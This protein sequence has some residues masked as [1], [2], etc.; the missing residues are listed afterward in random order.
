MNV[1]FSDLRFYQ[2]NGTAFVSLPYQIIRKTNGVSV[3]VFVLIP[4]IPMSPTV[5][6][7]YMTYGNSSYTPQSGPLSNFY[8]FDDFEDGLYTGR[9]A[10]YLNWT[11]NGVGT[12]SITNSSP[13][14]GTYSLKF[15]G[16][17]AN[18]ISNRITFP[19]TSTQFDLTFNF[20]LITQ[21]VGT[22][23]PYVWLFILD[24]VD[25]NNFTVL[26]T[27]YD[28]TYQ[29]L[30]I[31]HVVANVTTYYGTMNWL[32]GKLP[33]NTNYLFAIRQMSTGWIVWINGVQKIS[34]S[35]TALSTC[36]TKGLGANVDSAGLW[37]NIIIRNYLGYLT[38]MGHE[39]TIGTISA[40]GGP[41][42]LPDATG[43]DFTQLAFS[44]PPYWI[45]GNPGYFTTR[46][47]ANY[48]IPTRNVP[49]TATNTFTLGY[50]GM[51]KFDALRLG[52]FVTA[53]ANYNFNINKVTF[54]TG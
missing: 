50:D 38:Y 2:W 41:G 1:D 6:Y 28:G 46:K 40:E 14:T 54:R 11:P 16:N 25:I 52:I 17:A 32:T 36:V 10:P 29:V 35:A 9:T 20:K 4:N 3:T 8:Y 26:E 21:G 47:P 42:I 24:F 53:N 37:D 51:D 15:I 45:S 12:P 5:S 44:V 30:R 43:D 33:I 19:E 7:I 18:S 23:T 27:Y 13:I 48:N 31:R 49:M 39:P 34:Q 22:Q